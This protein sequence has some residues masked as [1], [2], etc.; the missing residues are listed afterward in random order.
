MK[1]LILVRHSLTRKDFEV[2]PLLWELSEQGELLAK[3]LA[4]NEVFGGVEAVYS[5]D[6][7]KAIQTA[8]FIAVRLG[9]S[10]Q[11]NPKLT[12]YTSITNG[13]FDDY[14]GT[15]ARWYAGEILRINDG[16]TVQEGLE[17]F[18]TAIGQI[19]VE[20]EDLDR[21]VVVAHAN[22]LSQFAASHADGRS[23]I[24]LHHGMQMP[25]VAVLDWGSIVFDKRFGELS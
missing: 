24:E 22:V 23:A 5:S 4:D 7:R 1:K 10:V 2:N 12:E 11:V 15:I 21:V 16:E 14:E 20:C 25:D 8:E 13:F 3:L 9:L 19:A 17:R 6:Q 18:T